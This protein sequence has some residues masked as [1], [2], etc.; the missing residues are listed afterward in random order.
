MGVLVERCRY[1]EQSGCASICINSCKVPTQ[2]CLQHSTCR[3]HGAVHR[4]FLILAAVE[5]KSSAW[6]AWGAPSECLLGHHVTVPHAEFRE[7]QSVP[8]DCEQFVCI[9]S[10]SCSLS[11]LQ[12]DQLP[13]AGGC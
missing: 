2:V 3:E 9:S 6:H 10:L 11:R 7:L 8:V 12:R 4:A 5:C 1:L 13:N